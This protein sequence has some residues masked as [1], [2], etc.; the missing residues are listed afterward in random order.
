VNAPEAASI[1]IQKIALVDLSQGQPTRF[2]D[3]D[4]R[5]SSLFPQFTPDG[6]AVVYSVRANGVDNLWYHPLD[7]SKGHQM[8]NFSSEQ[9]V[10]FAW[11]PDGKTLGVLR[12]HTESDVVLLR[13][14]Q[15]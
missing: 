13:Q 11:S 10:G 6:K 5:N 4:A 12:Q 7:G 8:T 14:S 2:L 9:I 1:V 15:P 3:A